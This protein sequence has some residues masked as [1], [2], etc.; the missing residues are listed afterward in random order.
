MNSKFKKKTA[1]GKG[2]KGCI[3]EKTKGTRVQENSK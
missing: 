1:I 3:L 2:G